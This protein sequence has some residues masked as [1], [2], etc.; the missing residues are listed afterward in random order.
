MSRSLR[1]ALVGCSL[2]FAVPAQAYELLDGKLSINGFG[3]LGLGGT[4]GNPYTVANA[5]RTREQAT[6]S[7]AVGARPIDRLSVSSQFYFHVGGGEAAGVSLDWAFAEWRLADTMRL[8]A[9][10]V[11][12]PFGL[13][14]ELMDVGT[15]RPFFMLPQ[16]LYGE[17]EIVTEAYNGAGLTGRLESDSGWAVEY[18]A[19]VGGVGLEGKSPIGA[20]DPE[21]VAE[22]DETSAHVLGARVSL[23]P[24][25]DGLRF[26]VSGYWG[27]TDLPENATTS[28]VASLGGGD[29]LWTFGASAEYVDAK[30]MV[31][32]EAFYRKQ[33]SDET[34]GAMYLEAGY[35]VLEK[36]QVVGRAEL[37]TWTVAWSDI[38]ASNLL[39]HRELA[40]GVAYWLSPNLVVKASYHNVFG[41]R[42]AYPEDVA[43]AYA[44][45]T[46]KSRTNAVVVGAQFSF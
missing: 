34:G 37:S 3:G 14:S 42:L 22:V 32:A 19:Y 20:L 8:R 44:D 30:V 40:I 16:G 25:L 21:R 10:R 45:G 28:F 43:Q 39:L 18:D 33:T 12:M 4:D 5:Q 6:M 13:F 26:M 2:L 46:L 23:L 35:F 41:N 38:E 15:L 31:R 11:K 36:L 9:G 29:K 1:V 7:L 24:P 27:S 17:T